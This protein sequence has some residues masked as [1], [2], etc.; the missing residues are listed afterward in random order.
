ME[1][2]RQR[3]KY[4]VD[5]ERR[6]QETNGN[7]P[8]FLGKR[9][10]NREH[11]HGAYLQE[12]LEKS[13]PFQQNEGAYA[14][15]PEPVD[16]FLNH[17]SSTY[18]QPHV[19]V[20]GQRLFTA[21]S[22]PAVCR[23]SVPV[24]Y[25]LEP[26]SLPPLPLYPVYQSA[27]PIAPGR[28][29]L[30]PQ[31]R[32]PNR[33]RPSRRT[34]RGHTPMYPPPVC[35]DGWQINRQN[36]RA[37]PC[38]SFRR[39]AL[40]ETQPSVDVNNSQEYTSLPP[41]TQSDI[42]NPS[43]RRF[44][45][46]GLGPI[47][48][49]NESTDESSNSSSSRGSSPTAVGLVLSLAEQVNSLQESNRILFRELHDTK[50]ELESL[51]LQAASWRQLPPDY[52]PGMLSGLVR[53]VRDAARVR[54]EALLSRVRGML[55][56]TESIKWEELSRQKVCSIPVPEK[57][58]QGSQDIQQLKD[59]LQ[60]ALAEKS[61]S[62]DRLLRIE[63]QLKALQLQISCVPS[64]NSSETIN[65]RD[66]NER[67]VPQQVNNFVCDK[68]DLVRDVQEV[69]PSNEKTCAKDEV[70]AQKVIIPQKKVNGIIQDLKQHGPASLEQCSSS[71]ENTSES[72]VSIGSG[73][74]G[75]GRSSIHSAQVTMSG[76]VTDL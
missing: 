6:G 48:N 28:T 9:K 69:L 46:P 5:H 66:H 29:S 41:V 38:N 23:Y 4:E 17:Q 3:S 34:H 75:T 72:S 18:W 10:K 59:Q 7:S 76:P 11:K 36:P 22:D 32:L 24:G 37:V 27:V 57:S 47:P 70:Y 65:S 25:S 21:V 19:P 1:K 62:D 35:G 68:I 52:E 12:W 51:K 55:G 50:V 67:P 73:S 15:E 8:S 74:I 14:F 71:L 42:T 2:E 61:R 53:E 63:D 31:V 43:Q 39:G 45:D 54:E 40:L 33:G 60:K 16:N 13:S 44:S 58:A 64:H 49:C 26:V 30:K 20:T 56:S